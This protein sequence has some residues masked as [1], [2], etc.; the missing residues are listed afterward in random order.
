MLLLRNS[1]LLIDQKQQRKLERLGITDR[2]L[3]LPRE[4]LI[5]RKVRQISE[6]EIDL[7]GE[8]RQL[9]DMFNRLRKL[10]AT[11]DRSFIGAVQAQEKK[12]MNGLGK[13]EKRLLK[14]QKRKHMELVER[15]SALHESLFPKKGLQERQANFSEFYEEYGAAL[16]RVL[17]DSLEPLSMEFDLLRL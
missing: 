14:A 16:I 5:R 2:E 11:T 9:Q 12:Q 6:I 4:E 3:F 15:I 13:L 1:V 8:A 17:L 10:A 7:S